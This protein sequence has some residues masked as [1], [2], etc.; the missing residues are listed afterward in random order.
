[1]IITKTTDESQTATDK[2]RMI[3]RQLETNPT[4]RFFEFI[5]KTLFFRKDIVFQMLQRKVWS[6]LLGGKI[7]QFSVFRE[8]FVI[9]E[10]DKRKRKQILLCFYTGAY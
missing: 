10:S 7:R 2:A 4:E 9:S 1:M 5:Y 6:F 3:H 8:L